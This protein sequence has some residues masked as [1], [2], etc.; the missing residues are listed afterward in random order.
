M[1]GMQQMQA[2]Q[3][4]GPMGG[5]PP[6]G[7]QPPMGGP[8]PMARPMGGPQGGFSMPAS[9]INLFK[10]QE[11]LKDMPQQMVM[12]YANG[13]NPSIVPPYIALGEMERRTRAAKN[14]QPAQAPQG[15]VKDALTQGLASLGGMQQMSPQAQPEEQPEPQ[16][17]AHGGLAAV[18]VPARMTNYRDGGIIGYA[19][20]EGVELPPQPT[21]AERTAQ[22][23]RVRL[24]VPATAAERAAELLLK[25]GLTP[26]E[27]KAL[28]PDQR[29]EL[30]EKMGRPR[31]A[32]AGTP[33]PSAPP[34][35]GPTAAGAAPV[36][37]TAAPV[38]PTAA[39]AQ[40]SR[41]QAV[42]AALQPTQFNPNIP[43]GGIAKGIASLAKGT[44]PSALAGYAATNL[45]DLGQTDT[46]DLRK[47]MGREGEEPGLVSDILTR[48]RAVPGMLLP[49]T[50]LK[51]KLAAQQAAKA[52]AKAP[53]AAPAAAPAAPSAAAPAAAPY[54]APARAPAAETQETEG[55]PIGKFDISPE[56]LPGIIAAIQK[57]EPKEQQRAMQA[58]TSQIAAMQGGLG[59]LAPA[60]PAPAQ[61]SPFAAEYQKEIESSR[62]LQAK[63]A[64][65][66]PPPTAEQQAAMNMPV[67]QDYFKRLQALAEKQG[68]GDRQTAEDIQSQ[69]RMDLYQSL[70]AAGEATRGQR[71]LGALF[72]GMGAS[73]G[74]A[75]TAR[76]GE[77]AKLRTGA[78]DREALLEKAQYE[79][80]GLERARAEGN[81]E[82]MLKHREELL[83]LERELASSRLQGLAGVTGAEMG[84]GSREAIAGERNAT[85]R[86]LAENAALQK[87][88]RDAA[89]AAGKEEDRDLRRQQALSQAQLNAEKQITSDAE[90]NPAKM[91]EY[92]KDPTA[93]RRDIDALA[94]KLLAAYD[95]TMPSA[96][97][98]PIQQPGWK[99][100]EVVRK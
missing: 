73:L 19:G 95:T 16:M 31:V 48:L 38:P 66:P 43:V 37:P 40:P 32:P 35:P 49:G 14:A 27:F 13:Q 91:A 59:S 41:F 65:P 56:R 89:T 62:A 84:A 33:M 72:G 9:G 10:V 85:Q 97:G 30:F 60:A 6:G 18:P 11:Q 29:A 96:A 8:P 47:A 7:G 21:A 1:N 87:Q 69:R 42:R 74:K 12:A 50:E 67:E 51:E 5:Q 2:P 61:Q 86:V 80:R 63:L 81:R 25:T 52:A 94:K 45:L 17:M 44:I 71:G 39:P 24:P 76:A 70:I 57:L 75:S 54:A 78:L 15:T 82:K 4:M 79:L 28:T 99:N 93:R 36:P 88:I 64:A 26:E 55:T 46:E 77:E 92:L 83:K 58:L 23:E 34:A 90:K 3:P 98:A 53:T 68:A 100:L 22:L 20:G